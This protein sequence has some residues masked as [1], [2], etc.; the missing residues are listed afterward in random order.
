MAIH[1]NLH[2]FGP[3][4]FAV[5]HLINGDLPDD[6]D[7]RWNIIDAPRYR[8]EKL[9]ADHVLARD[10]LRRCRDAEQP[11]VLFLRSFAAENRPTRAGRAIASMLTAHSKELQDWLA[12]YLMERS[13]PI[14]KLYGGSDTLFSG[15]SFPGARDTGVLSAHADNWLEI[16]SELV[17]AAAAI[18]FL[19]SDLSEGV[20]L[21]VEQIRGRGC[22]DRCLVVLL[23]PK[24]TFSGE[25]GADLE[26][27]QAAFRDFPHVFE[28][29]P[30]RESSRPSTTSKTFR[31]CLDN[32]LQNA[33]PPAGLDQ[34]LDAAFSYLEPEYFLS[35]DFADTERFLWNELRRLRALF[36]N[37][38]WSALKARNV[39]YHDLRFE[40]EWLPAHRAYGLA[41]AVADFAAIDA[42][43]TPL[44][45][46]Y[47]VRGSLFAFNI[48]ALQ[49]NYK[50]LGERCMPSGITNTEA[51]YTD[52]KD[53]LALPPSEADALQLFETAETAAQHEN[54]YF[55]NYLYQVAVNLALASDDRDETE[56]RWILSRMTHDWAVFQAGTNLA[57]WAIVNYEYSLSLS[58]EL[59]DEDPQRFLK[60]VALCLNN[61]GTLHHRLGDLEASEAAFREAVDIRRGRPVDSERYHENLGHSLMNLAIVAAARHGQETARGYYQESIRVTTERLADEPAA[62]L[63]LAHRQ[64]LLAHCLASIPG[65]EQDAE[66]AV[67]DA[68]ETLPKV[69]E[70]DLDAARQFNEALRQVPG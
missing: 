5:G 41:I 68:A 38:Y 19:I 46:L 31:S 9:L 18:V 36:H 28:L 48:G 54:L 21:E 55:A 27:L 39:S 58:R 65:A 2:R 53:P 50:E 20:R 69:E 49:H 40:T 43:L 29:E 60:D 24:K 22:Q 10:T 63:D 13:V 15:P 16:V 30:P 23:D 1:Y 70:I 62:V 66:E 57:K 33:G 7:E 25:A 44:K 59:S 34:S 26:D 67:E 56:S 32:K 51:H 61:L 14:I 37:T 17:S 47:T 11:F 4:E 12:F 52:H 35:E 42:A 3:D 8:I 6:E 45:L 64:I